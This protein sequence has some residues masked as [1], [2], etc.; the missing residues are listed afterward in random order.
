MS[1]FVTVVI[2]SVVRFEIQK[3][4]FK[5]FKVDLKWRPFNKRKLPRKRNNPLIVKNFQ[6]MKFTREETVYRC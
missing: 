6:I 1:G 2:W 3:L 5:P 4:S